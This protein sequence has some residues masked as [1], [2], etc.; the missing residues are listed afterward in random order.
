MMVFMGDYKYRY[1][2][3]MISFIKS[4]IDP[5]FYRSISE[6]YITELSDKDL[7]YIISLYNDH[8]LT[9]KEISQNCQSYKL[10]LDEKIIHRIKL[11]SIIY[12]INYHIKNFIR[13]QLYL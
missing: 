5:Y 8:T 11:E 13:S 7:N 1:A 10:P 3:G 6:P 12:K 2:N 4:N 9:Q